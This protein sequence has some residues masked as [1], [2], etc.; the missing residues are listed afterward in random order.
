VFIV[1]AQIALNM[2]N[3]PLNERGWW[4][5]FHSIHSTMLPAWNLI[6][7][8]FISIDFKIR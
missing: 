5:S 8:T 2:G 1:Y 4:V 7:E 3:M 6:I